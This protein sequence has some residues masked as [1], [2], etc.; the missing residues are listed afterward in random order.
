M[1]N[2]V[3]IDALNELTGFQDGFRILVEIL[4]RCHPGIGHNSIDAAIGLFGD[5][6]QLFDILG[7]RSVDMVLMDIQ[8]PGLCG[9]ESTRRIRSG[10]LA[11]VP[12][13][14]PIVALSAATAP[15]DRRLALDA[16]MTDYI[17]KPVTRFELLAVVQ[18][19]L[20]GKAP[21]IA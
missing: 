3:L 7:T 1:E 15:T 18:R 11:G 8:M 10:L 19:A 5:I 6:E 16:G 17:A 9:L 13:D 20:A 4:G 12:R 14:I 2:S 21:R